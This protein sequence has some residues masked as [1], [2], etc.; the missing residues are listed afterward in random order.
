MGE[1]D[2]NVTI[3]VI[4]SPFGVKG[5]V[6]AHP[7]TDFPERFED[8]VEV[9]VAG[10]NVGSRM[11]KIEGVRYHKGAVLIKF[12]G[13]GDMTAAESLRGAELRIREADLMPLEKDE[14]YIHD[15]IG[16]D[17]VTTEGES[18]GKVKEVLRSAANDVYVTER[19]MIPA[20]KEFVRS[21]DVGAKKMVVQPVEGLVQERKE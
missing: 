13:I 19:A 3:G 8:L 7:Y 15:I 18:L 10:G 6:K 14:Y 17:V 20:V 5:E 16:M 2:R 12:A 1:D 9:L 11:M 21:V 4:T